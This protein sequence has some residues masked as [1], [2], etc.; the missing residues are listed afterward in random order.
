[1]LGADFFIGGYYSHL[2]SGKQ[3]NETLDLTDI[4]YRNEAGLNYGVGLRVAML[5]V[6]LTAKYGLTDFTRH[7]NADGA[8]IRNRSTYFTLTYLF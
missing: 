6:G 7:A 3:G 4:F 8:H 2:F 5:K 1:M